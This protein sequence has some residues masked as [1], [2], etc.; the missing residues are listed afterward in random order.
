MKN[1][2]NRRSYLVLGLVLLLLGGFVLTTAVVNAQESNDNNIGSIRGTVYVDSNADGRCGAEFGDPI[3]VGVPIEFVSNDGKFTTYLQSGANGTYGL[4][5]AGLGTWQ[6]SAR[7]NANDFVVTGTATRSVFIGAEEPLA[8]GVDFCVVPLR[9]GIIPG[10]N[11]GVI[12][13]LPQLP[14]AGATDNLAWFNLAL[15]V[16]MMFMGAGGLTLAKTK[17]ES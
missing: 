16:G 2:R 1:R 6:V 4:V 9:G 13:P 7:P 11:L 15:L 8:L 17:R 5:A 12:V 14:T 3:H 10:G